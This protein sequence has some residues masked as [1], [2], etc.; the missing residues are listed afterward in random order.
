MTA[1]LLLGPWTP[2]LF[3]GQ[4]FAASSPFNYF[5]DHNSELAPLVRYRHEPGNQAI[6]RPIPPAPPETSAIRPE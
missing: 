4:E 5:A 2:M 6:A 1:L 3:Q